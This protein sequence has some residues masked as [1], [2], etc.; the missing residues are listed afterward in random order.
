MTRQLYR[1]A[2]KIIVCYCV[3]SSPAFHARS[4][5]YAKR[6]SIPRTDRI[7]PAEAALLLSHISISNV[8]ALT[9]T[10]TVNRNDTDIQYYY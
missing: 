8:T 2:R 7:F 10:D 1:Q 5:I 9:D 4:F 6:H 3:L